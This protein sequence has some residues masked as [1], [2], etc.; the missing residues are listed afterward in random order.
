MFE[1]IQ[2]ARGSLRKIFECKKNCLKQNWGTFKA[3]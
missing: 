1:E 2:K 3:V